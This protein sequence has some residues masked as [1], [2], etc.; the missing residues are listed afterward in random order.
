MASILETRLLVR[1]DQTQEGDEIWFLMPSAAY[2]V[3]ELDTDSLGRVRHHAKDGTITC[4]YQPGEWLYVT[5]R[6]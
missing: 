4:S 3:E 1:A 6:S 2:V 5:R